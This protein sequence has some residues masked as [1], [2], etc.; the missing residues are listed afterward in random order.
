MTGSVELFAAKPNKSLLRI[1]LAGIGDI[2]EGFDG[3][4]GWSLSPMTGPALAQGTELEQKRFDADFYSELHDD[5]R[6]ESMTTVEKTDFDGRPCYK[7]RLVRPAAA[8]SSSSTT[9]RAGSRPAAIATRDSPM[10]PITAT[11]DRGRLQAVRAAAAGDDASSPTAMGFSR[12][13]R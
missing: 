8:R 1:S 13:S 6:Y 11:S 2:E 4:I 3:T 10:G 12:W 9:S 5:A 7:V